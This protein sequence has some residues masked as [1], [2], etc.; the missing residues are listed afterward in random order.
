MAFLCYRTRCST[1]VQEEEF[2]K[3]LRLARYLAAGGSPPS[4]P[5]EPVRQP[6]TPKRAQPVAKAGGKTKPATVSKTARE[7]ELAKERRR[8]GRSGHNLPSS[9]PQRGEKQRVRLGVRS[10]VSRWLNR[11]DCFCYQE[12]DLTF[13]GNGLSQALRVFLM[14]ISL[15][16]P[17]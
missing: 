14:K 9:G 12:S 10:T 7:E 1:R 3:Q 8:A 16:Y 5:L 17:V 6:R 2:A 13:I 15:I 4:R 11:P